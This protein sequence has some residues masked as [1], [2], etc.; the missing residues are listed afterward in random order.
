MSDQGVELVTYDFNY[1]GTAS[2]QSKGYY[3][4][5]T[6]SVKNNSEKTFGSVWLKFDVFDGSGNRLG[7]V[8]PNS[9][10]GTPAIQS[11]GPGETW[12]F[13]FEISGYAGRA[14]SARVLEIEARE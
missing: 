6:G 12:S 8:R 1:E 9:M 2:L 5:L 4:L 14:R 10:V 3:A 7:T 11:L 13:T